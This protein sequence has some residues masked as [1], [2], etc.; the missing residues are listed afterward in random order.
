MGNLAIDIVGYTAAVVT[1]ISIFP[2]AYDVFI[3]VN[4]GEYNKLIGISPYMF[5]LQCSGCAMWFIYAY[6][7]NLLPIMIGSTTCFIPSSYILMMVII[8]R[9]TQTVTDTT[10]KNECSEVI[11]STSTSFNNEIYASET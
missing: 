6:L 4:T 1:N 5:F 11:V 10:E 8:Y 2:Q 9:P 3:I 7:T